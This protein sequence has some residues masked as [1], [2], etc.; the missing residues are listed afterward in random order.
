[1][2]DEKIKQLTE[3]LI[4]R[5]TIY[6]IEFLKNIYDDSLKFIRVSPDNSVEVLSKQDNIDFFQ[7]LKDS[8]A[9]PLNTKHHILFADNDGDTGTIILKRTMQQVEVE[10]D[11]IFTITWKNSEGRWRIIRE[12]VMT[13]S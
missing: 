9:Q 8:N 6:D 13:Q 7:E 3:S 10:K 2:I 11:Y 12:V 5:G 4:Q 1:M